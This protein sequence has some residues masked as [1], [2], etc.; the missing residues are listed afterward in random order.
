MQLLFKE[1]QS[2]LPLVSSTD[3]IRSYSGLRAKQAPPS[4]GGFRDYVIEESKVVPNF[5]NLIGIESPGLTAA[6]PIA[7]MVTTIID[8]KEKLTLKSDFNPVR[9]GILKFDTQDE[10][11]KR[12]LIQEN[13][14][15]GEII[16]RCENITRKEV[17]DALNNPLGSRTLNSIKYRTRAMMG[18]CQGGYCLSRLIDI[19]MQ[20]FGLRLDEIRLAGKHSSL[21]TSYRS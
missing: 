1:A 16:C 14:N 11:M 9:K 8:K 7:R 12:R 17:L 19:L 4:E 6:E 2:F 10:A 18:R 3:I 5:I 15:Y 20:C 21:F 13:S